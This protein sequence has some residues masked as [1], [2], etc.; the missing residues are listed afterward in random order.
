M[1]VRIS[2]DISPSGVFSRNPTFMMLPGVLMNGA[3]ILKN[4]LEFIAF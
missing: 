3:R 1:A 2:F 4:A